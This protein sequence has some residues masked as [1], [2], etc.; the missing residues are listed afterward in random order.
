MTI[1]STPS[2]ST[3]RQMLR[4]IH[5]TASEFEAFC[6]DHFE[7]AASRFASGMDRTEKATLL[8]TVAEPQ[9]IAA[10]LRRHNPALF[11]QHARP[12]RPPDAAGKNPYRG[13]AAFQM[14][15]AYLFFGREALIGTLW[16]RFEGL[17]ETPEAVRLLAIVGPSGS[18]KSSV[19]RAG[20]L[21]ALA[22]SPIPGPQPLRTVTVKPGDQPVES[23][24][25]ALVS[26]LPPDHAVLPAERVVA[27]RRLLCDPAAPAE[28]LRLFAAE[29]PEVAQRPVLVLVDQF[30]E[31]YTL[32]R[33]PVE[34][35]LFVRLLLHAAEARSRHVAVVLTLRSDFL[36]ETQ[37]YHN[38]LNRMIAEQCVVVPALSP[39]ALRAA[40]ARPA[41]QA[42]RPIDEA[43]VLLLL[44]QA[45]SS[46]GALPLLE[47]AL[48][49]IWEGMQRGEEPAI[50][51]DKLGGVGGALAGEA[52]KIYNRLGPAEQATARRALVRLVQLGEG[53]RDTRRRVSLRGLCGRGE[54]ENAVLSVLRRF[55]GENA[56]LVTL[57]GNGGETIAEVTHEALFDH[58]TELRR[59]ID[60]GR[61]DRRFHDRVADAARLWDDAGQPT[62]RLWRPPDLDLL[63]DYQK[64]HPDELSPLQDAFR[65]TAERQQKRDKLLSLGS[66]VAVL[67]AAFGAFMVYV[68]K[69]KQRSL[70]V[71]EQI[72]QQLLSTYV[73]Q[74][75]R[76]L[77]S[78][79]KPLEALAWLHRAQRGGAKDPMLPYLLRASMRTLDMASKILIR[80]EA[81]VV[82]AMYRPD[83][84]RL[85]TASID[86]MARV[87]EAETGRLVAELKGHEDSVDSVMYSLDGKRVVTASMNHA[88]RVWEAE[89]G[90][91]VAELKGHEDSVRSA[92]YSPDGKRVVTASRD[93]TARVWE[94]ESGRLVADV[95]GNYGSP[96]IGREKPSCRRP[97]HD[98][99][100]PFRIPECSADHANRCRLRARQHVHAVR[101]RT[102]A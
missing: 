102:V 14:E 27:T 75:R 99:R 10:A 49:K 40:I 12:M 76:L 100:Q 83:G 77:V 67:V 90:I 46:E 71:A 55:A 92:M 84:K 82:S 34:R 78:E 29:L 72:R 48:T 60:E 22:Q 45:G 41:E 26:L 88:A 15:D 56:R 57:S 59:W 21:A 50:T 2:R 85:V 1:L 19:A 68:T 11:A 25:R 97:T 44:N 95:N 66:I 9:D 74:G 28:G 53:T 5:P 94:A 18:G 13:L 81:S 8:L 36:G 96:Y 38:Q 32:C 61:A 86:Q 51:L 65:N 70:D 6:A 63:R 91:L 87:W 54:D 89:T 98:R 20:L 16:Q 4:A 33:E 42:G 39:E 73:E 43:T 35:D 52:Q 17:W 37:R 23:L 69:E 80:H 24:A 30:E 79:E 47:F 7:A 58:W 31:V 62:G 101:G 3:L 93:H 64:R